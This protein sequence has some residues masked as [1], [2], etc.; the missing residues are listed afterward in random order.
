MS[1]KDL[2]EY[3]RSVRV[4]DNQKPIDSDQG[5]RL[6]GAGHTCSQ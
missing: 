2:L 6:F 1:L 3:R 5:K 4:Y